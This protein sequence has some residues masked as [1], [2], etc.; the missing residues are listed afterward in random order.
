MTLSSSLIYWQAAGP[1]T[2]VDNFDFPGYILTTKDG[3]K[4]RI[5]RKDEGEHFLLSGSAS[6]NYV[7]AYTGGQIAR[8]TTRHG[9]RFEF[10]R[11]GADGLQRIDHYNPASQGTK[12]LVFERDPQNRITALY[13]PAHLDAQGDPT[14][15]AAI[16]YD[17]DGRLIATIDAEGNRT[18]VEY[19]LA[20][21]TET[22]Y[23]RQGNPTIYMYV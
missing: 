12:S 20:S 11:D 21:R 1:Y 5:E 18:E 14:G 6:G 8:I 22:V 2:S 3:A 10:V 4:Y 9:D 19:D 17:Y 7:E 15:P 16:T 23:D 13:D